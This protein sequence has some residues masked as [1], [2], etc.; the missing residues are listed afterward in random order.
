MRQSDFAWGS[1]RFRRTFEL[2]DAV[3]LDHFRGFV[4]YWSVPKGARDA[5]RGS[6]RRTPGRALFGAIDAALGQLPIVAEN[7]GVITRPVE[8]LRTDLGLPGTIVL[9]FLF[10]ELSALFAYRAWRSEQ[11]RLHRHAR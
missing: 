8:Q 3:R 7:L 9:Q 5:R 11:R 2:V 1:S 6:W 4:A 10:S